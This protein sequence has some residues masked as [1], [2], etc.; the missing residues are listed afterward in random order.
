MSLQMYSVFLDNVLNT[1]TQ[2]SDYLHTIILI[3]SSALFYQIAI[4]NKVFRTLAIFRR[5]HSIFLGFPE[6]RQYLVT[7]YWN[8]IL[9]FSEGCKLCITLQTLLNCPNHVCVVWHSWKHETI[10]FMTVFVTM[11]L[12]VTYQLTSDF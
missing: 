2:V 9:D 7:S 12:L 10:S 6:G 1:S 8:I 3:I 4:V 5:F 11:E